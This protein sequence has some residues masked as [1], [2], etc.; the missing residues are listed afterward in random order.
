MAHA[1]PGGEVFVEKFASSAE[2][3][4]EGVVLVV[5]PAD[6]RLNDEAAAGEPI[7]GGEFLGER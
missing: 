4:A 2:R 7:D 5:M 6:G 1:L 3:D